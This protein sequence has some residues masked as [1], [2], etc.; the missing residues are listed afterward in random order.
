MGAA[1]E[2]VDE[3]RLDI[4]AWCEFLAA[5]GMTRI[6]LLGH[7]LG[8]I[9]AVYSQSH[10]PLPNVAT[11]LALSPPRLSYAAFRNG[12]QGTPFFDA[13]MTAK[14]HVAANRSDALMKVTVPFPM[15][16]SAGGYLEKY[17]SEERYNLLRFVDRLT[18]PSFFS[19]GGQELEHGG[20]AFAGVPES[21][22]AAAR[23]D[24]IVDVVTIPNADHNYTRTHEPLAEKI[25]NWL[26]TRFA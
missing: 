3:S 26:T 22:R 12:A 9:K 10:A 5:R 20:V 14:D 15:L 4:A 13:I 21:L 1:F 25:A 8:A 7:S 2:V 23:P 11:V 16:M 6:G 18:C 17:G 24:Q 19:Y